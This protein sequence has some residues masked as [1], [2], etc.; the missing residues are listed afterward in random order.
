MRDEI[1]SLVHRVF[2]RGL[3]LTSR[4]RQQSYPDLGFLAAEHA[5]L[6]GQLSMA[7]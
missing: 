2:S 5:S 4:L 7:H 6:L 3:H 1:A